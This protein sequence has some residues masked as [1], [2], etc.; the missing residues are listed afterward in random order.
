[1]KKIGLIAVCALLLLP[2]ASSADYDSCGVVTVDSNQSRILKVQRMTCH[3]AQK[4]AS[5]FEDRE[6]WEI[7]DTERIKRFVCK[8]LGYY[9]PFEIA[10]KCRHTRQQGKAFK[11][12]WPQEDG[13]SKARDLPKLYS[14]AAKH[15][16]GKA[17]K[18]H[19]GNSFTNGYAH[20]ADC[21][22]RKSRTR[23]KCD[24]VRWIIGDVYYKGWSV[25][26]YKRSRADHR[27]HWHYG[28]RIV[29]KNAF[30]LS[31]GGSNCTEVH[32]VR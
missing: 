22:H 15:Y 4:I 32:R 8:R 21:D 29:E 2:A 27:V 28:F 12:F 23:I 31:T 11:A 1:M 26:W 7:G 20:R 30:C 18:R 9:D 25:I 19:F 16:T 6:A 13:P 3:G 10:Y 17:M 14:G 24:P 5:E